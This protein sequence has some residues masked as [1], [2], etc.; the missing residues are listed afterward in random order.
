[1]ARIL[2][3]IELDGAVTIASDVM[4]R[5]KVVQ[6]LCTNVSGTS[7]GTIALYGSLDKVNYQMINFVGAAIGTASPVASHTGADLNQVTI[8][9]TLVAS[10]VIDQN[11]YP[12]TKLVCVGTASDNTTISGSW[13]K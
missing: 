5:A 13:A 11:A 7:D 9:D 3:D 1:M 8:T 10:W 4:T 2:T 6:V 12:Y